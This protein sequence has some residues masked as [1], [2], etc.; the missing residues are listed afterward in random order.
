L[1]A[2]LFYLYL[3]IVAAVLVLIVWNFLT[4]EDWRKKAA[5]A[6]VIVPLLLRL[7]LIK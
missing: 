1:E 2:D 4:E 7:F 6:M 5:D 3:T